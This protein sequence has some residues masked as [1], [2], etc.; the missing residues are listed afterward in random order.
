MKK[1]YIFVI[2]SKIVWQK[3]RFKIRKMKFEFQIQAICKIKKDFHQ[4]V[5]DKRFIKS[6]SAG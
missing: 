5:C 2:S 3:W 1:L 6:I 4:N